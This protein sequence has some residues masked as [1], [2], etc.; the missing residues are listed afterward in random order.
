MTLLAWIRSLFVSREAALPS[1]SPPAVP[2]AHAE[3]EEAPASH[4]RPNKRD[5]QLERRLHASEGREAESRKRAAAAAASYTRSAVSPACRSISA[6]R[7]MA[8]HSEPVTQTTPPRNSPMVTIT[9]AN[10]FSWGSPTGRTMR[11]WMSSVLD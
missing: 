5:A 1:S 8:A 2:L 10:G 7:S 4:E 3:P 9:T 6:C 11:R